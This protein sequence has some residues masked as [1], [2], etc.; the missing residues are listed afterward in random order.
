MRS[1][2]AKVARKL[3]K[4][5]DCGWEASRKPTELVRCGKVVNRDQIVNE[6]GKKVAI[7][8]TF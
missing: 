8:E 6:E 2:F 3:E 5:V 1:S 7:F 4:V